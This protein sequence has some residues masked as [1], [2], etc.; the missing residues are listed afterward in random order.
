[1]APPPGCFWQHIQRQVEANVLGS[2]ED[3]LL[4]TGQEKHILHTV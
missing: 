1:M 2:L 3:F 4:F